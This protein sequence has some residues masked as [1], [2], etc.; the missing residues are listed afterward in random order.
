MI[1]SNRKFGVEI[2]FIAPNEKALL[3]LDRKGHN[4]ISD[5]SLRDHA[6]SNL[7]R[8]YVSPPVSGKDGEKLIHTV[9]S[10]MK[11]L[12]CHCEDPA[13]SVHVHLDGNKSN[14][15]VRRTRTR[16]NTKR[17]ILGVSNKLL[18]ELETVQVE[19]F[20]KDPRHNMFPFGQ[21]YRNTIDNVVYF[22]KGEISRHPRVNYRYFEF[23]KE[24]RSK[25]LRNVFYFYTQYSDVLESLVSPS[26]QSGNMYCMKLSKSF[27]LADIEACKTEEEL[28]N[29]W[30]KGRGPT[31]PRYDDSRYHNVN[32]DSYFQKFG[33]VE[34]RSHGGTIDSDKILLWVRLHQHIVDKL[35][36]MELED[37]KSKGDLFV[38]FVKFISDDEMIT[39]YVKRLLGYFSNIYIV[40][41]KVIRK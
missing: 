41:N 37:I 7:G 25:W 16:P 15:T 12:G 32:L 4:I 33:T 40:N 20:A 34:I 3:L 1:L 28:A 27:K 35:E 10:D 39:E 8:E 11:Q 6:Q 14:G 36:T 19:Y 5:G 23:V 30:Y 24:D 17:L 9:C 18:P 31:H 21:Y 22:S 38:D 26:R 29:V 13:T 2:E